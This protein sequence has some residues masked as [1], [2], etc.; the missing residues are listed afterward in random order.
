MQPILEII[1][2]LEY[3]GHALDSHTSV[4]VVLWHLSRTAKRPVTEGQRRV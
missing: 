1:S 2:T 3:Q 4:L